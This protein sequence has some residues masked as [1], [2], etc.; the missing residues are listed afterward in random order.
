MIFSSNVH[1]VLGGNAAEFL[2]H[3][4]PAWV[5]F[6]R[7]ALAMFEA[8]GSV[9]RIDRPSA[10]SAAAAGDDAQVERARLVMFRLQ[11]ICRCG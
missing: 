3:C 1:I 11:Q 5:R 2:A 9:E 8:I 4:A 6:R 10:F 7:F